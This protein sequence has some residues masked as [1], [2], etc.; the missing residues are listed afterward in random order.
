MASAFT[1]TFA[2]TIA[3]SPTTQ[4]QASLFSANVTTSNGQISVDTVGNVTIQLTGATAS[5][6]YTAQF[7]PAI[8]AVTDGNATPCFNVGTVGSDAAGSGTS[9]FLFPKSG[10]WAGD[11]ELDTGGN[12]DYQTF[13]GNT[14]IAALVA[15]EVYMSTLQPQ[16]TVNGTGVTLPPSA[17][18][19]P[20]Q[21]PL[22]SGTITYSK[23]SV[24]FTLT[25][26][27]PSMSH[28]TSETQGLAISTSETYGL[29]Q[30][31]TDASGNA[32][33][34]ESL[35]GNFGDI[36]EVIPGSGTGFIGG[37]SIPK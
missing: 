34:T 28:S 12:D 35:G 9:T 2:T 21:E 33:S 4:Y 19:P 20:P 32:S 23:G 5:T 37:F 18:S 31:T 13:V 6:T 11:F 1:S 15:S 3:S 25:G 7:C 26:A 36:F 30:F 22:T 17:G 29:G 14:S 27:S 16:S 24:Q 10:S 8:M